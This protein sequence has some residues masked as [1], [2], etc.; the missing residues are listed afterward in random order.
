MFFSFGNNIWPLPLPKF[1]LS[2][3]VKLKPKHLSYQPQ[4]ILFPAAAL[5]ISQELEQ[6]AHRDQ[7]LAILPKTTRVWILIINNITAG[8]VMYSGHCTELEAQVNSYCKNTNHFSLLF[9]NHIF[10]IF[11]ALVS[12]ISWFSSFHKSLLISVGSPD[13]TEGRGIP[14]LAV[15]TAP[16]SAGASQQQEFHTAELQEVCLDAGFHS[17]MEPTTSSSWNKTQTPPK[18]KHFE[19]KQKI[20]KQEEKDDV[21]H[22]PWAELVLKDFLNIPYNCTCTPIPGFPKNSSSSLSCCFL[23]TSNGQDEFAILFFLLPNK[24]MHKNMK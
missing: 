5:E 2:I 11:S 4:A 18:L 9:H 17:S 16:G 22:S 10:F 23:N 12:R 21:N 14:V 19:I 13:I 20:H 8:Q 1:L 3:T 15:I 24:E 7:S 6:W